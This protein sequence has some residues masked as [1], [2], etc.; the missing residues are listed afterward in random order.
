MQAKLSVSCN[1][2]SGGDHLR[3]REHI[4]FYD[5]SH[6]SQ[7]TPS[8]EDQPSASGVTCPAMAVSKRGSNL[9]ST[10]VESKPFSDSSRIPK[11][12]EDTASLSGYNGNN[13]SSV[14]LC[15]ASKVP[16]PTFTKNQKRLVILAWHHIHVFIE[17]VRNY[18]FLVY[19]KGQSL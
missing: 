5:D 12:T 7:S 3:Q 8:D 15:D 11:N 1:D 14:L 4:Y 17:E 16:P 13:G 6:M 10:M 2:G 18:I 9:C 19:L